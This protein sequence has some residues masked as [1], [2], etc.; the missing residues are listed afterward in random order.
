MNALLNNLACAK[1][2]LQRKGDS[3]HLSKNPSIQASKALALILGILAILGLY[4]A[5]GKTNDFSTCFIPG[6]AAEYKVFWMGLPL[7]WSKTS[8]DTITENGRELIRI[9][10]VSKNYKAYSYI[11]KVDDASEVIVDPKTALPLRFDFRLHEG[12]R[13]KSHLTTFHHDKKVAIFKDRIT[14]D[15]KEVPIES[16]TQDLL[17]FLYSSRNR[18]LDSLSNQTHTLFVDGKLYELDLDIR[19][20]DKIKLPNYGKV[21]SVEIE[22][23]AEFDG[24]FLRQGKIMFWV[25]K[26]NRRMVTCIKAKVT[27]GKITV[28]LQE[29]SGPGNDFWVNK[30][31]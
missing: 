7:A 28:K 14:K 16:G 8:V 22:P 15:I 13:R 27:V 20:D 26:Q 9:R 11:Y 21:P 2:D 17:S 19:R 31:R 6:E 18:S 25:S 29:V 4:P 3:I 5:Y 12:G 1:P 10:M 30:K 23:I 24:W